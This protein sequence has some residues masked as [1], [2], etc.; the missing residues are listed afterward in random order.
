MVRSIIPSANSIVLELTPIG[1]IF[2]AIAAAL[3]AA[4][5]AFGISSSWMDF[6]MAQ[7]EI[8]AI[9]SEFRFNW[10][11]QLAHLEGR[12]LNYKDC[13]AL[14]RIQRNF[15]TAIEETARKESKT[16]IHEF[17]G[18]LS[19]M[20]QDYRRT[21]PQINAEMNVANSVGTNTNQGDATDRRPAHAMK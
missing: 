10:Y 12:P 4:D 8:E 16:W 9:L 20:A 11:L 14:L 6:R 17:R 1:Y 19:K 3:I 7:I 15:A 5:S 18:S 13:Q 21:S 2:L